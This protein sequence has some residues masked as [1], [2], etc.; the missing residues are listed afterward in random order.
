MIC[1]STSFL[2]GL[3][4]FGTACQIQLL[5][6]VLLVHLDHAQVS[7]GRT[8]KLN[9]ILRPTRLKLETAQKKY[10]VIRFDTLVGQ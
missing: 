5:M 9:L 1:V 10:K 3:L 7:F 4:V 6:L 2:H 8:R